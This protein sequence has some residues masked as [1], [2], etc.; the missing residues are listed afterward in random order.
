MASI[1]ILLICGGWSRPR[2]PGFH[3]GCCGRAG[4]FWRGGAGLLVSGSVI[5]G[6]GLTLV[7]TLAYDALGAG[8]EAKELELIGGLGYADADAEGRS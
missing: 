5:S 3:A 1:A 7:M 2:G 8:G 6:G 4:V